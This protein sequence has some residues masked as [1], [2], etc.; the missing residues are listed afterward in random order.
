[1]IV[2]LAPPPPPERDPESDELRRD[3]LAERLRWLINLRW[4]ALG[5]VFIAVALALHLNVVASVFP[6]VCVGVT[7]GLL[8]AAFHLI[9]QH[10][11]GRSLKALA[12]EALLQISVDVIGL[13]LLI[14]FAGGL[15]NP[16][17]FY[18]SFHV[19]IAAILL[20]KRQAYVVALLAAAVVVFLG[21]AEEFKFAPP[22]PLQGALA[23]QPVSTL[24]RVE[25]MFA[26]STTLV[27]SVYMVTAIMESLRARTQD[28]RRLNRDLADRVERLA[29][30]ERKLAA[31]HQRARA[32]LECMDEGVVVVD[33]HGHVMLANTAAQVS[34]LAA[35]EETGQ[36]G[37][38]GPEGL[39]HDCKGPLAGENLLKQHHATT[40][41]ASGNAEQAAHDRCPMGKPAA[42]LQ[43]A[44]ANG[45]HLCPATLALLGAG[46]PDR[47]HPDRLVPPK[48]RTLAQLEIQ[49]R[50][51]ENTVSAVRSQSGE[52]LGL[53]IVSRDVTER[54]LL[55]RQVVHAEKLNAL[56]NLAAGVA[57]ELNTPLGTILG[58]AQ[59]LLDDERSPSRELK[60]IEDQ[61]RR[62][63]KIVQSLLD[64][65]HKTGGGREKCSPNQLVM[66]VRDL[67]AHAMNLRGIE[68]RLNLAEPPPVF[69]VSVSEFEQ[70]LVNLI[71]NA[72]DAL[73]S[74]VPALAGAIAAGE[75]GAPAGTAGSASRLRAVLAPRG[76]AI[77]IQTRI[78]HGQVVLAVE[79]NGPGVP[80]DITEQIFEPFFTTKAAGKGTGLGLSIARR[81]VEDH[82]G[83]LELVPRPD[84]L[85][86]ARFEI[87]VPAA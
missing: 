58:Y 51:Y 7:M 44:L 61:A 23:G 43:E 79:D 4:V 13:A 64:L 53:V 71:T 24:S 30:A 60:A 66:K 16:F 37:T 25:L 27:I 33:L 57:H 14:F 86:G 83:T 10:V 50:R 29:A 17:V 2:E 63:R 5:G 35:L 39:P 21:L 81:I 36:R 59:M 38:H 41:S 54:R 47:E 56:G 75:G 72:A 34:A 31:E 70:V 9:H 20:E 40:V 45:G 78:Q 1:M 32:I 55:E 76:A 28:V 73:E 15:S 3:E 42:C 52:P 19:V 6:L 68:L 74:T 12:M 26:L 18:F 11:R 80:A 49:G 65:A 8:N 69:N 48:T 77:S 62:C 22:S 82:G 87:R 46:E 67:L 84:D 85:P